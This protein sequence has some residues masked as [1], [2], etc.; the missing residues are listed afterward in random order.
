MMRLFMVSLVLKERID[1]KSNADLAITKS[2]IL[3]ITEV[4]VAKQHLQ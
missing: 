1:N 2:M 4:H 3:I